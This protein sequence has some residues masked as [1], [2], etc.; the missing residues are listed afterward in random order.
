MLDTSPLYSLSDKSDSE[1]DRAKA[2]FAYL[3]KIRAEIRIP[4]P[5]LLEFHRLRLY[6][7]P[8]LP[9]KASGEL[10]RL[11]TAFPVEYPIPEDLGLALDKLPQHMG[12][13]ITLTDAIVSAMSQRLSSQVFTFDADFWTLEVDVLDL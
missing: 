13:K 10:L 11:T 6:R 2:G 12:Q 7:K 9:G 3:A 8:F 5:C 1:Y 4:L